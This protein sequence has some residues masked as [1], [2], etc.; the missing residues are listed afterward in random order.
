MMGVDFPPCPPQALTLSSVTPYPLCPWRIAGR[1][2]PGATKIMSLW[3][4]S[5]I[6]PNSGR[7]AT[8]RING[9][10]LVDACASLGT[11]TPLA[12]CPDP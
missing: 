2:G 12:R 9:S 1:I 7:F 4:E 10:G 11:P 3:V 5:D 6:I 8:I